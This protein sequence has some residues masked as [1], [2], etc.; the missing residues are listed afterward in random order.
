MNVLISLHRGY[1]LGDAVQMSAVL[2]HVVAARPQWN[3]DFQAETGRHC[4]GYGIA[5]HTFSYGG[6]PSSTHYDLEVPIVLY[7]T[8]AN[9]CD[10]PNTRVSSCLYER[11]GL[12]WKSDYGQYQI[13]VTRQQVQDALTFL[14]TLGASMNRRRCN[15][16]CVHY[17]GDS[18]KAN[19]DLAHAQAEEVCDH[20]LSLSRIPLLL[21]WR[22]QWPVACPMRG[23]HTVGRLPC[24]REWGG[25]AQRNCALIS[26]CEAFVGID[27][28]PSKCASATSTPALVTWT[29][30]TPIAF[31]DP[32]DNTTHLVPIEYNGCNPVVTDQQCVAW[33]EAHCKV[34]WYDNDPV[35]EINKWLTKTLK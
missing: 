10:R 11:F 30:H 1:G 32:A 29:G 5:Q 7:D 25:D 2:R 22:D 31:H 8:W 6:Q 9:W 17:Q 12:D 19:K 21:D 20:V 35:G 13:N 16:V 3:V 4:V 33:F 27:S 15:V 14:Q 26:Q 34:R 24:A 28:G 23:V 18:D